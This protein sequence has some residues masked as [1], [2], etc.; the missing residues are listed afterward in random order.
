MAAATIDADVVI[1]GAGIAGASAAYALAPHARVFVLEREGRP[2]Y[3]STGRSAALFSATYGNAP[4]RALARAGRA[5]LESPPAGFAANPI[6]APRGSL[7]YGA[8]ARRDEL[9]SRCDDWRRTGTEVRLLSGTEARALVPPLRERV[10]EVGIL[11]PGARDIDVDALHQGFLRGARA[12]GVKFMTNAELRAAEFG[13]GRWRLDTA[14]GEIGAALLV[15]AAGAW[16]DEV[17]RLAGVAPLG[18]QPLRRTAVIFECGRFGGPQGWPM[19]VNADETLYFKADAG[20]FLASPAD[21]TPSPPC[22]AQ[23]EE[24]DVATLIDRLERETLFEVKR[25]TAKWAGLR[26]FAPDRTPVCGFDP[27]EPAFFW[28]AG[29]GGYGI[30]TSPALSALAAALILRRELPA[31]LADEGVDP[32]S[33]SPAR[34][35]GVG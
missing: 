15:N 17:A 27:E 33:I 7:V 23:P 14:A 19:A 6:L 18:I 3:H 21:Q 13:G 31:V 12:S 32:Q 8:S 10:A 1:V 25:L 22:D 34:L 5:F 16:A 11:E 20:R 4:V 24:L 35:R 29:Q 30:K 28:L 2:G 26:S 9:A